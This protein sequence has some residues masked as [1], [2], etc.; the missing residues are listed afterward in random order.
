VRRSNDLPQAEHVGVRLSHLDRV[1]R[2]RDVA[3]GLV[4]RIGVSRSMQNVVDS[5]PIPPARSAYSPGPTS[6]TLAAARLCTR[7]PSNACVSG[8]TPL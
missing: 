4:S 3:L 1:Q 7:N 6:G 2:A 8:C 5:S